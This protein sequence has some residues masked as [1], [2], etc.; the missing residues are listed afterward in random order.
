[1]RIKDWQEFLVPVNQL[2]R[3]WRGQ[4][5]L[6]SS[7]SEAETSNGVSS[8]EELEPKTT[9][10]ENGVNPR[11]FK[12]RIAFG[13]WTAFWLSLTVIMSTTSMAG[14]WLLTSPPATTD[15]QNNSLLMSDGEKLYC[16]Q[17]KAESGKLKDIQAGMAIAINLPQDHPL[18]N[19]G[20]RLIGEW[21]L[22]LLRLGQE[23]VDKGDMKAATAIVKQIPA[24]S[25]HY[26]EVQAK[27]KRWQKQWQSGSEIEKN[28][29]TAIEA[30]RWEIARQE[31]DNLYDSSSDYWRFQT[32]E[33]LLAQLVAEREGWQ[34]LK[35]ARESAKY[36]NLGDI[37]AA[38]TLSNRIK[39]KTHARTL[40]QTDRNQW[41]QVV[42]KA[43]ALKYQQQ[44]FTSAIALA[45]QVPKDVPVAG[46]AKDWLAL[47]QASQ[48]AQTKQDSDLLKALS[49]LRQIRPESPLYKQAQ[50]KIAI[51]KQQLQSYTQQ[52][53]A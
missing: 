10:E 51:W 37:S 41:S 9:A 49:A 5:M 3:E 48:K 46:L 20:Q 34:L 16:A 18:Y 53:L 39:P 38:I 47:S 42:L 33:K 24:Q 11:M 43:V 29:Q 25:L 23:K 28:F 15:C 8:A 26:Q 45:K 2:W 52:H 30:Q 4:Q 7:T 21:S 22:D 17:K 19:E 36:Q 1:M 31:V 6:V 44:D 35:R 50:A 27:T 14:Y 32:R 12:P 13:G 40:A